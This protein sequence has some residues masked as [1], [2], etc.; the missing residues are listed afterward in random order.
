MP[1]P[2]QSLRIL[3][4][5]D[6]APIREMM[7]M[8]LADDGA[9]VLALAQADAIVTHVQSWKPDRILLDW[10][11]APVGGDTALEALRQAGL[12]PAIPLLVFS[13]YLATCAPERQ[14]RELQ[15]LGA[16]GCI[17]KPITE[18]AAL[19]ALLVDPPPVWPGVGA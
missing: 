13:A 10:L 9:T 18:W 2:L 15:H 17:Q 16:R 4:V 11:M 1:K 5:D 6:D 3:I 14:R 19:V 7:T 12:V 8:L